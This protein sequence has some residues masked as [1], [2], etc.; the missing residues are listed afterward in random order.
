MPH[1]LKNCSPVHS[2][3]A[4]I[5]KITLLMS[6]MLFIIVLIV[7]S[8][9]TIPVCLFAQGICG[10]QQLQITLELQTDDYA[11][12]TSWEIKGRNGTVYAQS[13][14]DLTNDTL[15]TIDICVPRQEC[16][17]FVIRDVFSDGL[18]PPGYY[19]LSV[20][21]VLIAEGGA[22][23]AEEVVEFNCL[24]GQSCSN[25]IPV[26]EGAY[27]VPQLEYW[28][29]FTPDSSGRF[30]ISTCGAACDTRLYVYT[31]CNPN[32]VNDDHEGSDFYNDHS[33]VC[34]ENAVLTGL[35][36]RDRTY[37]I[38]VGQTENSCIAATDIPLS[39]RYAGAVIGCTDPNSC[40][41]HP[42]ATV[43]D[44]T[45]IPQGSTDCPDAA[46]LTIREDV[47]RSSLRL[48]SIEN[49]DGCLI[50]EGC[51]TGYGKRH[52]LRFDTQ[53]ENI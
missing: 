31:S 39:I 20:D 9:M 1:Y 21:G 15:Y 6:R 52:I 50:R 47:L 17:Q 42:L 28:Y 22:F 10:E 46:D 36:Q 4:P 51:L 30:D 40:N 16:M 18:F 49:E 14:E 34:A 27:R 11:Y 29:I 33:E 3:S 53:I 41:Y 45:C 12:E 2:P 26:T 38:R 8:Y 13:D 23:A 5:S 7:V 19:R 35:F 43:D 25:A 48:D 37:Y 24:A 44:G 32:A